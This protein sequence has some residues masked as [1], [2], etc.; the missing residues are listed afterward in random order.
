MTKI[1]QFWRPWFSGAKHGMARGVAVYGSPGF[2]K[3]PQL[4]ADLLTECR[5]LRAWAEEHGVHLDGSPESL[6]ALDEALD[7]C[8]DQETTNGFSN[9]QA[10]TSE[11]CSSGAMTALA[12]RSGA[13]VTR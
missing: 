12:G 7:R 6:S 4:L 8:A 9:G 13:T 5:K 1:T 10:A 3:D 11:R 2:K